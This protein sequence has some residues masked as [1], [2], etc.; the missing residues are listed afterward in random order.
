[1]KIWLINPYGPIPSEAWRDYSFSIFGKY[2]A[3]QGHE[4]VW[5]TSNFSHH[6]KTYRSKGFSEIE[7]CPGFTVKL[8][9]TTGYKKNVGFGRIIRD[10]IFA[11]RMY[12][13]GRKELAPDLILYYESMLCLGYA[14]PALSKYHNCALVYDQMDL[15]PELMV[16]NS[17]SYLR[18]LIQVLLQ[19]VYY[20]RKKVFDRLDGVMALAKPYLDFAIDVSPSLAIGPKVVVYNGIDVDDFREKMS[21]PPSLDLKKL[22]ENCDVKVVFAGSLGPSYDI[23]N[24]IDV[25]EMIE[26]AQLSVAIL[27]AGDGPMRGAVEEAERRLSCLHYFGKLGPL[28]LCGLY[29][30]CD[31][32]LAAYGPSSNVEM[33]DKF[34]DYTAASLGTIC[35]LQGEVM[36]QITDLDCGINYVAGDVSSLF[37]AI[38]SL[39]SSQETLARIKNNAQQCANEF[40]S[41]NQ[42]IKL[43]RFLQEVMLQFNNNN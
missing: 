11:G 28:D 30:I 34:Y 6:F 40:S 3:E 27:I 35:S 26:D 39:A 7:V 37:D 36:S 4:V 33:P 22:S 15:W 42:N 10:W 17:P 24:I 38:N 32:G 18:P 1:M 25:A 29:R 21:L 43:D 41:T 8:I 9:P 13:A 5:W 16:E 14:G 20:A 31:I 23:Q 12:L 19:P 2:L